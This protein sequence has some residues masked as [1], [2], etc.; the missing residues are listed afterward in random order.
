MKARSVFIGLFVL[1]ILAGTFLFV[2]ADK[3]YAKEKVFK[4]ANNAAFSG[5][6]ATWGLMS[7]Y[8]FSLA[9]EDINAAGGIKVGSDTYKVEIVE[10]DNA[11]DPTIALT[12]GRKAIFS[13]GIKFM[14]VLST[15]EATA[16]NELANAEKVIIFGLGPYRHQI[17]PKY[18][19]SFQTYQEIIESGEVIL[20]YIKKNFPQY[21]KVVQFD[22]DDARGE[23]SGADFVA[24]AK[25]KGFEV[26]DEIHVES[27]T[28]DYYSV[29]T[30]LIR[31][32]VDVISGGCLAEVDQA[33][34]IKQGRELG[35]KG[36]F[37]HP[38]TFD[39]PTMEPICGKEAMEGSLAASQLVQM[40]TEIGKKWQKRYVEQFGSLV[41]WAGYSA[42]DVLWLVKEA[43]EKAGTMDTEKVKDS[44]GEVE[45]LGV[46]GQTR[47]AANKF[48]GG[49]GRALKIMMYVIEYRNGEKVQVYEDYSQY[50]WGE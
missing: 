44:L 41:F 24:V 48:S 11:A 27:G 45:F 20:D 15:D 12:V 40:P 14:N 37:I 22:P 30:K 31:K 43:I 47:F 36:V 35:F 28:T 50:I 23:E 5:P 32:G 9:A 1:T 38:D 18:P 16:C 34:I 29:L 7:R 6:Y 8:G 21:K 26:V 42:Y 19:Y 2:T 13:D 3:S 25:K 46:G 33:Y 49:L 10:Y 39:I 4:F 17:G